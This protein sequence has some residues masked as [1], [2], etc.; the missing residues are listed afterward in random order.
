MRRRMGCPENERPGG[1]GRVFYCLFSIAPIHPAP[2]RWRKVGNVSRASPVYG[3]CHPST[4]RNFG[5]GRD[6]EPMGRVPPT[7][8][9]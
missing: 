2:L 8:V 7:N 5:F 9:T 4:M 6:T 1:G 3:S